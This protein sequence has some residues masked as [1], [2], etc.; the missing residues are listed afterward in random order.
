MHA[1]RDEFTLAIGWPTPVL[2]MVMR[3]LEKIREIHK[4][5]DPAELPEYLSDEDPRVA[6]VAKVK[7]DACKQTNR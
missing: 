4:I 1:G 2:D 5:T 3:R 7:L 6:E